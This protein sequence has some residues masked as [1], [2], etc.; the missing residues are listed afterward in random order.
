MA[1]YQFYQAGSF[2]ELDGRL[3]GDPI[4]QTT[5]DNKRYCKLSIAVDAG[6][7]KNGDNWENLT[8]WYAITIWDNGGNSS[9]FLNAVENP[10]SDKIAF[11]K[12]NRILFRGLITKNLRVH[13]NKAYCDYSV[14]NF[15][16]LVKIKG[17]SP[18]SEST[19]G[20]SADAF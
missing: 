20:G 13:E 12:G 19:G 9:E 1:K 3:A 7:K 11:K 10:P 4:I 18:T 6:S 8:D 16:D 17:S 14:N 2:S 5:K 15:Y